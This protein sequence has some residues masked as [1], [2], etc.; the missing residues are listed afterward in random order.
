MKSNTSMSR[1]LY[2]KMFKDMKKTE[3]WLVFIEH[4]LFILIV[5]HEHSEDQWSLCWQNKQMNDQIFHKLYTEGVCNKATTIFMKTAWIHT[6]LNFKSKLR[7]NL[8][9]KYLI[10]YKV[11]ESLSSMKFYSIPVFGICDN[12][13]NW[14]RD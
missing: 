7:K 9:I 6:S 1:P 5:S 14:G 8:M 4:W 11:D 13:Y 12:L 10:G 3:F 2:I